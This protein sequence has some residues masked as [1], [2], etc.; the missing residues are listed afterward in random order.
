MPKS[1]NFSDPVEVSTMFDGVTSRWITFMRLAVAV[2]QTVHVI[3]RPA[4]LER[5]VGR[6]GRRQRALRVSQRAHQ[7]P[8]RRAVDVF[9]HQEQRAVAL[10]DVVRLDDVR[11]VEHPQDPGLGGEHP[12]KLGVLAAG[13]QDPLDHHR[14]FEAA[15]P[16]VSGLEHLGLTADPQGLDQPVP[17]QLTDRRLAGRSSTTALPPRS[18]ID[19]SV[20]LTDSAAGRPRG[21]PT[22]RRVS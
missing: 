18:A 15:R 3:E 5:E 4:D 16:R 14:S 10:A 22:S 13:G 7:A 6:E 17:A 21:G 11:M 8:Q 12:K 19:V 9:E 1:S 20:P 2:A